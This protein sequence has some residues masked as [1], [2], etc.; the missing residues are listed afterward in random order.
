[1]RL[2]WPLDGE[3]LVSAGTLSKEINGEKVVGNVYKSRNSADMGYDFLCELPDLYI[4]SS[5]NLTQSMDF[6]KEVKISKRT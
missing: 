1:M 5:L 4:T 2:G 3:N 6:F